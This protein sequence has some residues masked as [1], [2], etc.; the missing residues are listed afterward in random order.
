MQQ[1]LAN[2]QADNDGFLFQLAA[3]IPLLYMSICVSRS[4]FNVSLFGPFKLRGNRQSHGVALVFNAQY[5]VR[6]QFSLA[7]NY[8]LMLKY[9]TSESAFS[10]FLGQMDVIPL[11]GSSFP[12]YAPLLTIFLSLFTV[13]N[14]YARLLNILGFDHQDAL[15]VG[16]RE[17]LDSKVNDG[18]TLIRQ[19]ANGV[20][21]D[22][23]VHSLGSNDN[24]DGKGKS[25]SNS[26]I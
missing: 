8:L 24:E 13:C 1:Y 18:K 7:Y 4:F 11:F 19:Y 12:V 9:D 26:I 22:R 16:D 3:L 25:W 2:D 17:T 10:K 15:L 14:L 5:L 6:L 23:S 20:I 21:S